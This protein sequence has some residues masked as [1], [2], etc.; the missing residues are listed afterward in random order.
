MLNSMEVWLWNLNTKYS[1]AE[2]NIKSVSE[3]NDHMAAL[4][5]A[6]IAFVIS[7]VTLL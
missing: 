7:S 4:D 3:M 6:W 5:C 1:N 2:K